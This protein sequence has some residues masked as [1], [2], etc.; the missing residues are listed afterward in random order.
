MSKSDT[1]WPRRRGRHKAAFWFLWPLDLHDGMSDDYAPGTVHQSAMLDA[2][3][4]FEGSGV[5]ARYPHNPALY[6]AFLSKE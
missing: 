4:A 3:L 1:S 6:R 2:M 5:P